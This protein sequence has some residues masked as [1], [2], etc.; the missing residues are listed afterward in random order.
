MISLNEI[1]SAWNVFFFDPI[2]PHSVALFRIVFSALLLLESF[3]MIARA[4]EYLGPRGWFSYKQYLKRNR[5]I[6]FSLFL[7]MPPTMRSVYIILSLHIAFLTCTMIGLFTPICVVG[8]FATMISIQKRNR[9]LNN[10][11]DVVAR[12]MWFL[13]IFANSGQTYSIDEYL[14]YD[15]TVSES[16]ILNYSSWAL[17]LMQIQLT[18]I[19][20]KSFYWKMQGSSYRDGTALYYVLQNRTYSRLKVPKIILQKPIIQYMT[21]SVLIIQ[22]FIV[23][24]LWVTELRYLAI[25]SGI[26]FHLSLELTMNVHLFGWY[27][28][29]SFLL[30]V[31]P[32]DIM[33][34]QEILF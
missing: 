6:T 19:Y 30:F 28:M 17:R 33:R 25:I 9:E 24:G 16:G 2:P 4:K 8:A 32:S 5:K 13:L 15:Q 3:F 27:M 22:S 14:F 20:F 10:G 1:M 12:C 11:G 21:W 26:I 7:Y 23:V 29:T 34:L 18:I 31:D